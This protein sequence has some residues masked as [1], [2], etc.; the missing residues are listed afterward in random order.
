MYEEKKDSTADKNVH[1]QRHQRQTALI[2]II[3]NYQFKY[4]S[5]SKRRLVIFLS[6]ISTEVS[7]F[8]REKKTLFNWLR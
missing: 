3:Q 5:Y 6:V 4:C 7:K 1:L 2:K 8:M